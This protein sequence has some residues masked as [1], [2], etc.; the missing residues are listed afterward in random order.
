MSYKIEYKKYEPRGP[1]EPRG[2]AELAS[3]IIGSHK[4]L[5]ALFEKTAGAYKRLRARTEGTM[6]G[7]LK[8]DLHKSLQP[9]S[10][11]KPWAS[12]NNHSM[13]PAAA[14]NLTAELDPT[15][16]QLSSSLA[17]HFGALA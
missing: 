2:V 8:H 9:Y 15:V 17:F 13:G 1:N 16:Q 11:I 6:Q 10:R 3:T 12:L 14:L 4:D 5:G 7:M